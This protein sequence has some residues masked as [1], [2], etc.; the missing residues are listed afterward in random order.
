MK[1]WLAV[2]RWHLLLAL[3]VAVALRIAVAIIFAM[4][5][6]SPSLPAAVQPAIATACSAA[7][8]ALAVA[9]PVAFVCYGRI[10][11]PRIPTE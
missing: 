3:G 10:F 7:I 11:N 4:I 2:H 8:C 6:T 1:H 5:D 9:T